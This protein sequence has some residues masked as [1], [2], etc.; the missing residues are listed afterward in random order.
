[1]ALD[2]WTGPAGWRGEAGYAR[3]RRQPAPPA[4]QARRRRLPLHAPL[5]L[6]LHG[7]TGSG[8]EGYIKGACAAGTAAGWRCAVLTYRGCGGLALTS[9]RPYTADGTGDGAAALAAAAAAY[10]AAP[11]MAAVGYSLGAIILTKLVA[12]LEA[13]AWPAAP[14]L[15]GAVCI[16]SPFCLASAAARLAEPWTP[17]WVYNR[18]LASR[19]GSYFREHEVELRAHPVVEAALGGGGRAALPCL[20]TVSEWDTAVV[21]A[22]A[23]HASAGAYYAAASSAAHI[24]R[25]ATTPTLFL[26][27]GDDPFLGALPE[28][29]VLASP[30][31]ALA[32][33]AHGGHCAFL[34][35]GW[36]WGRAWSD[37]VLVQW[38]A[39]V[40]AEEGAG[41]S[42]RARL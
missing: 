18:V 9:P 15:A 42:G 7:L 30:C 41:G 17:G 16:S 34:R 20:R 35:G 6:V 26:A 39:G 33:S 1:M 29:E 10:P 37:D 2:W 13:G 8:T 4:V 22:M 5:L 40:R 27:A 31:T 24:P 28:V 12:E 25:I 11:C 38:L 21:A 14:P 19:L 36:P 32:V 3:G 23:G